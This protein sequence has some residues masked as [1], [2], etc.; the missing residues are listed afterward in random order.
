L[1]G[2]ASDLQ[3]PA[4]KRI[5]DIDYSK[6]VGVLYRQFVRDYILYSGNADILLTKPETS[7]IEGLP[8]WVP[9]WTSRQMSPVL[10]HDGYTEKYR[11]SQVIPSIVLPSNEPDTLRIAASIVDQVTW[12]SEPFEF[13]D[14]EHLPAFRRGGF[15]IRIWNEIFDRLS[16]RVESAHLQEAFWRTLIANVKDSKEPAGEQFFVHFLCF[17]RTKRVLDR[18]AEQFAVKNGI[19]CRPENPQTYGLVQD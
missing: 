9:D 11:A 13:Q 6:P 3:T 1:Y 5:F 4:A 7:N 14:A 17:W 19:G 18:E 12:I 2:L 15:L 10:G 16:P 8:S